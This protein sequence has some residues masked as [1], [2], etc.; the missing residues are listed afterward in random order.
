MV[1]G[2]TTSYTLCGYFR[3]H[4]IRVNRHDKQ[5]KRNMEAR[6]G[7]AIGVELDFYNQPKP[8]GVLIRFHMTSACFDNLP[9]PRYNAASS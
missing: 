1:W 9:N 3:A 4:N 5:S 2:V 8:L 6:K 7:C